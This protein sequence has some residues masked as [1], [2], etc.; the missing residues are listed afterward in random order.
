MCEALYSLVDD[1]SVA[2]DL[3]ED[4]HE[5]AQVGVDKF[6]S[7]EPQTAGVIILAGGF[8]TR[9]RGVLHDVPKPLASVAD[10]PFVEWVVRHYAR[11]GFREFVLS[12]GYRA[13]QIAEHFV[14]HPIEG[15]RISCRPESSPLGT[16][17]GARN[18]LPDGGSNRPWLVVN[19]DSLAFTDPRPL[20]QCLESGSAESAVLGLT[21]PDA[22]RYG[23]L[24]IGRDGLLNAFLEKQPGAGVINAGVYAFAG[25]V[26]TW[27]PR[28]ENLSF[29]HDVFPALVA[30]R[31]VRAVQTDAPFLDIGTPET[32]AAADDF[33]TQNF[34]HSVAA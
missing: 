3:R 16:A 21:M 15:L 17:G 1:D 30:S 6:G 29:E 33:I 11:Y 22:S 32:L 5:L 24:K 9:L 14:R 34:N 18:A 10:R 4:W 13:E 12:T 2:L 19:G 8:G 20:L 25:R 27:L 26:L 31:R 28:G 23:T 7:A